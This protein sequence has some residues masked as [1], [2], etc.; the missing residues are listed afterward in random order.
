MAAGWARRRVWAE[1]DAPPRAPTALRPGG[2]TASGAASEPRQGRPLGGAA[3]RRKRADPVRGG[4]G[5]PCLDRGSS[6]F[7]GRLTGKRGAEGGEGR[8][9]GPTYRVRGAIVVGLLFGA[10]LRCKWGGPGAGR[11]RARKWRERDGWRAGSEGGPG[12]VKE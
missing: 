3:F 8:A 9:R 6:C 5:L 7:G 11:R 4:G 1:G 2:L 10:G 12:V